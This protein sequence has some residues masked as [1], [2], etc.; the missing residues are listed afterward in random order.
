MQKL[1]SRQA[2][3]TIMLSLLALALVM[4]L[5]LASMTFDDPFVTYRYARNL[6]SGHG[7]VYNPGERV[8]STTA[9]FYAVLLAAGSLLTNDLPALS[10]WL[11]VFALF[12]GGCFIYLLCR[13]FGQRC[14]GLLA[15]AL[16]ITAP[17]LWLSL[18]FETAFYLALVLGAFYFYFEDR[19]LISATLLALALLTRGD[20]LL[21]AI[22]LGM[23]YLT[24]RRR[25]PWQALTVYLAVSAPFIVYLILF[26]G[27]PLPVT[28]AAK[29]AQAQLGITGFYPH[30]TFLQGARILAEAYL[31]QSKLYALF[32]LCALIGFVAAL[33]R[34][35]WLWPLLAWDLLYFFGYL[36]LGVA[37]YH[38]Y[39][40][41]LVPAL[42]VLAATGLNSVL[43]LARSRLSGPQWL[44]GA[45]AALAGLMLVAPQLVSNVQ[46]HQALQHPGSVL[47]ES[48][49]YKIL[50]EAK[51]EVYRHVGEWL[52]QNTPTDVL[53]GVTEVGVIGYY[54]QRRMVDFLGLLRPEVADALKRGDMAWALLYYQPDYVVLTRVNPLYSYDLHADEW[55]K[56]AYRPVQVFTDAR[57]WGGPVT[58]YRRQTP[59][60]THLESSA[61]PQDAIPLHVRFGAG[62]E[63]LAYTAD[64]KT[65]RPSDILNVTLYW[66]CL[67]P[68]SQDYTAFVHILGQHELVIAQHDGYP[69][70]GACPTRA[71]RAGDTFADPHMLALP[72]TTFTPD[73]AQLEVGLYE[74]T[75]QQR[76]PATDAQGQP[77]GDNAR[78]E[79]FTIVPAQIGSMPNPMQ[80]NFSDQIALVGYNMDK[81]V[82]APGQT[83]HLTLYWRGLKAMR[84][85]YSVF[86]HLLA[87]NGERV[88]QMD[89]WPQRG[90]APTSAWK[91]EAVI[92]DEYE[93]TVPSDA[94][95]GVYSIHIGLY[96]AETGE[97][98]AVLDASGQPQADHLVLTRVRVAN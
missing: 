1:S 28:L 20:G 6:R 80:V 98:L 86:T 64:K 96:L 5:C 87:E 62:I 8:L 76:L 90:A 56:L 81:R 59:R 74:R 21:P 65:L 61:I 11:N 25:V 67:A 83:C 40:A 15:A 82:L 93:L 88:A 49:V 44:K 4:G 78:F 29:S 12:A 36:W 22:A 43:E 14:I 77:L 94:P 27:S 18:G 92:Q 91:A 24:T 54:A 10:N 57:F 72:A 84:K 3:H 48:K 32:A 79:L 51:V 38:W 47:P 31:Q 16:F 39:Y 75:P 2:D 66:K 7:L 69:C 35:R 73:Q 95:L 58:I 46:M 37:P 50:P 30:T 17:L 60:S 9:P 41:P 23:H 70:L 26:F 34:Y 85:N 53:V 45:A 42:A 52:R 33:T 55:F 68:V 97:R 89:S 63:L 19:L 13:R 71:W